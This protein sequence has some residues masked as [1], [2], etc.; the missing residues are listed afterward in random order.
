MDNTSTVLDWG[1]GCGHQLGYLQDVFGVSG[2]GIDV[3]K[4]AIDYA[5]KKYES[6]SYSGS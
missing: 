1:S 5:K 3:T 4:L 2:V 6:Q